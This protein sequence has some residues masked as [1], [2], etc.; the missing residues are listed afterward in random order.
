MSLKLVVISPET[1]VIFG[2]VYVTKFTPYLEQFTRKKIVGEIRPRASN[3]FTLAE[4]DNSEF[5]HFSLWVNSVSKFWRVNY[6]YNAVT[7]SLRSVNF[8]AKL[9]IHETKMFI[10]LTL[11]E[12]SPFRKYQ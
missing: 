7:A 12:T 8:R 6:K 10:R 2:N 4:K 3:S 5:L 9:I 11:I 1:T